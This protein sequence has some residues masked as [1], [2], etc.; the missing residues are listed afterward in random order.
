MHLPQGFHLPRGYNQRDYCLR[1]KKDI[2]GQKQAGRIWNQHLH[3]GLKKI[4]FEKS[5]SDDC[6]Y[7]RGT[8][9]LLV[10][11]DDTI[12]IDADKAKVEKTIADLRDAKFKITNKGDL[13]DFLGVD[14][15]RHAD[16]SISVTQQKLIKQILDMM[17][18]QPRTKAVDYPAKV[19]EV[20]T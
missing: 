14:I 7:F 15:Q 9:L 10:Y 1:L 19:S 2:Y 3:E 4:G 6:L 11:V 16:G 8:T 18:F 13:K 5:K 12:I 20:L 17:N